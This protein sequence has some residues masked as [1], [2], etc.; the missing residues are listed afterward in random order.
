M[1]R[2]H[3]RF[4]VLL[5]AETYFPHE[6]GSE[7]VGHNAALALAQ[8]GYD[9][10]VLTPD[11]PGS[12]EFDRN[13]PYRV[14]RSRFWAWMKHL[15]ERGGNA[16][17]V[18]RVLTAAH[19]FLAT[20]LARWDALIVL[21][22]VPMAGPLRLLSCVSRRLRFGWTYQEELTVARGSAMMRRQAAWALGGCTHI[23]AISERTCEI[24]M[25]FGVRAESTILQYP[26]PDDVFFSPV[27]AG[28]EDLRKGFEVPQGSLL[29]ATVT[30]LAE[31]KGVD[32]VL[33][34]L[35][36]LRDER[37]S[38]PPIVYTV[39]GTGPEET[40]LRALAGELRLN[41][42]VRFLGR[43]SE[44]EKVRLIEAADLFVMPNRR[45]PNG[46]DEGFGIVFVE[47]ALRGTP[48]IGG[49]SGGT[50]SALEH[51]TSGWLVDGSDAG[52]LT[53]RLREVL[54][55][56]EVLAEM[57][58]GCREWALRRFQ[59]HREHEPLLKELERLL[60]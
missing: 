23:I 37:G 15:D 22:L 29:L 54:G 16:S 24:A 9:V 28:R 46:E 59:P 60:A 41:G 36:A 40:R 45:L 51:G 57:R 48:C 49:R 20:A 25:E 14:R 6:G 17:R 30:R 31:R 11:R 13:Q 47:A 34:A 18:G 26:V 21:H 27:S 55:R 5:V 2:K 8:A 53:E 38:E 44:Q 3:R 50:A 1:E 52:E 19:L 12:A 42:M 39:A 43:I 56:P 32:T 4:R 33:H 10:T 7:R 35:A 58:D